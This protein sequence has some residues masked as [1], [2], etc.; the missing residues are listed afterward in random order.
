MHLF[1]EKC[2]IPRRADGRLALEFPPLSC[3][4]E[5]VQS[6]PCR[7]KK[8]KNFEA[9]FKCEVWDSLVRHPIHMVSGV[10]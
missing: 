10:M 4:S 6:L 2:L 7:E 1:C 3:W 5:P 9:E 8:G